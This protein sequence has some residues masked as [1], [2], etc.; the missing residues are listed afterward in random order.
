[1]L[2]NGLSDFSI[3]VVCSSHGRADSAL[4]AQT[5]I[6]IQLPSNH[7][8]QLRPECFTLS[9]FTS[10]PYCTLPVS[11][12]KSVEMDVILAQL[13]ASMQTSVKKRF[14]FMFT[15]TAASTRRTAVTTETGQHKKQTTSASL[16]HS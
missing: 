1:M 5:I 2:H 6:L 13:P 4:S 10:N 16:H 8:C 3:T 7:C 15:Q 11:V 14:Q 9:N 12:I